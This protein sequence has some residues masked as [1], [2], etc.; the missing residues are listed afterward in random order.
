MVMRQWDKKP[1]NTQARSS[2]VQRRAPARTGDITMP[3]PR[4]HYAS[5]VVQRA[6]AMA[7]GQGLPDALRTGIEAL[8]GADMSGVQVHYA[9]PLPSSLSALAYAQGGD[10]HLARGQEK[11]LPHEAWH[12]AQQRLGRVRPTMQAHG[13]NINDDPSLE[14]EADAMG[15]RAM[16]LKADSHHDRPL[17]NVGHPQG[18]VQRYL[19]VNGFDYTDD[20]KTNGINID[21][22][23]GNVSALMLD[24]VSPVN[25]AVGTLENTAYQFLQADV[26]GLVT[27]QLK[28]WIEDNQ[29][30]PGSNADFGRKQQARVYT[31]YRD[32]AMAIYGWVSSKPGRRQEK[33][34]ANAIYGSALVEERLNSVLRKVDVWIGTKPNNVNIRAEL[35]T[36][37]PANARWADYARW[38]N[39]IRAADGRPIPLKFYPVLQ[40]P[41]NFPM[42]SKIATLHDLMKYFLQGSNTHGRDQIDEGN[43]TGFVAFA[44]FQGT[45]I[46]GRAT[47]DRP[48]STVIN[49]DPLAKELATGKVVRPA[50]EEQH[51]SYA[52]A[53]QNQI[54]MWAR[55]SYTAARMMRLAQHAGA[56]K[57]E[58]S[59]VA[60]SIIAFW[61]K[62]YDHRS[63][64]YHTL[65]EVLDF[66]PHFGLPYDPLR[67]YDDLADDLNPLPPLMIRLG[68]VANSANWNKKAR[69]N[70]DDKAPESVVAIRTELASA[71]TDIA[72]LLA[73]KNLIR[74]KTGF[75]L[76]RTTEARNFYTILAKIPD[77]VDRYNV[78]GTSTAVNSEIAFKL[79]L[80]VRELKRFN[81]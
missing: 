44:D 20:V 47:Y 6:Q 57:A 59:A 42:R 25:F 30:D 2:L 36:N 37:T 19:I 10:I 51:A 5:S 43:G 13:V 9:S 67:R 68:A 63:L 66:T 62:D 73:I 45:N 34:L 79:S 35:D 24:A 69:L 56:T 75:S 29:G 31:N 70:W 80:V 52:Y 78:V 11:H 64:P 3:P 14:R 7:P 50:N 71:N 65:H 28:K 48:D 60:Q 81:P 41:E 61:R 38:F 53:R 23:T 27:R 54:P 16:Q 77:N 4:L 32:L 1:V 40:N 49:R 58:I 39:H 76:L 74:D 26:G 12:V 22:E 18:V 15:T 21:T 46:G 8:S 33:Q 72:K 55:H 17:S